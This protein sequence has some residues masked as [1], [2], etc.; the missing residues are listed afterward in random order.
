[1]SITFQEACAIGQELRRKGVV[2]VGTRLS[3]DRAC[4][5]RLARRQRGLKKRWTRRPELDGLVPGSAEY[6]REH[7]RLWRKEGNK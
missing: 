6:H 4:N 7:M 1:M 2:K 5:A 3:A